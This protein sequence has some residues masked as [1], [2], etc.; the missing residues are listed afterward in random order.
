MATT[1]YK[2]QSHIERGFITAINIF[3][4]DIKK[5]MSLEYRFSD[6][7]KWR[8]DFAWVKNM[9]AVEVDGGQW[10][11]NGGRHNRDSD[12]E[13]INHAVSCGWRVLRFSG[14]QIENSPDKCIDILKKTLLLF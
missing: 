4:K 8:F 9:V 11:L 5:D 10:I 13:K 1:K 14:E 6:S 12:R 7:R 2:N 3:G